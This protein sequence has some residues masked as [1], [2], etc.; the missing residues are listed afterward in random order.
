[1]D[2]TV[3]DLLAANIQDVRTRLV[4]FQDETRENFRRNDDQFAALHAEL[5]DVR[6][7]VANV[8]ADMVLMEAR[9]EGR[10]MSLFAILFS[11]LGID[12]SPDLL[13]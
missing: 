12:T 13:K 2:K 6:A 1:M 8:R 4:T 10:M 11:Y 9:L 5:G 7:E 3:E